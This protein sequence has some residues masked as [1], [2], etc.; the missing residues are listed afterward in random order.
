M[1]GTCLAMEVVVNMLRTWAA[2]LFE[3]LPYALLFV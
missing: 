1:D 2:F 3:L